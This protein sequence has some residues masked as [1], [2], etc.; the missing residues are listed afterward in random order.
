[1]AQAISHFIFHT[2]PG[3][4][5]QT[6]PFA[7]AAGVI[8]W[9]VKY[10]NDKNA[11]RSEKLLSVLFVCYLADL[12]CTVFFFSSIRYFWGFLFLNYKFENV[13]KVFLC[14]RTANFI[15]DFYRHINLEVILNVVLFLPF[16]VLYPLAKKVKS[17]KKTV[18]AGVICTVGVEALQPLVG[19]AFDVND[20]IL[21][22]LG[23]LLSSTLFFLCARLVDRRNK[24]RKQTAPGESEN[25]SENVSEKSKKNA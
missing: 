16:G 23:I 11:P 19:R 9:L 18:L 25:V 7:A 21:N 15:P 20:I 6:L 13:Y 17:W 4:F 1:M 3:Y 14:Q 12:A 5:L 8:Y 24:V 2:T 10:R 22:T